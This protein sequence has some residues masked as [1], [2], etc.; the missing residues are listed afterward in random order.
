MNP[1]SLFLKLARTLVHLVEVG[2]LSIL[3]A[4]RWLLSRF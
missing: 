4:T 2:V 1:L 3:R